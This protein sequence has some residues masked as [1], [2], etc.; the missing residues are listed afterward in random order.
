MSGRTW[1]LGAVALLLTGCFDELF[2]EPAGREPVLW[3][4][5]EQCTDD[6]PPGFECLWDECQWQ[7]MLA[8]VNEARAAGQSCGS[9]G[10]W[11]P[12]PPLELAPPLTAA[13][14]DHA[15][16]MATTSCFSH[17]TA[18]PTPCND[19]TPCERIA[20][21]GYPWSRVGE[22]ISFGSATAS[23]AVLNWLA[24][25]PHCANLMEPDYEHFGG[26]VAPAPNGVLYF[27]QAFG[28]PGGGQV[29]DCR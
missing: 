5:P 27:V 2:E 18:G 10:E 17:D 25:D 8:L 16:H 1:L 6:C 22:N 11:A 3:G 4:P 9:F 13:A 15:E 28:A 24:S 14:Q 20:G 29:G 12:A 7:E 26:G 21:A 23:E 19:G